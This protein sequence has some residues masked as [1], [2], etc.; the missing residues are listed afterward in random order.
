MSVKETTIYTCPMHLEIK[1]DIEIS[2]VN[3]KMPENVS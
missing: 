3:G 1:Q 2:V